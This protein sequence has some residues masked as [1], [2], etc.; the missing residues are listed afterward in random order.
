MF[1]PIGNPLRSRKFAPVVVALRRRPPQREPLPACLRD[2]DKHAMDFIIERRRT[3]YA[4]T[5]KI[6]SGR[7]KCI[8][9][10]HWLAWRWRTKE[11]PLLS[12]CGTS[13]PR[14]GQQ[15]R[16]M[17][18]QQR[19][20][21]LSADASYSRDLFYCKIYQNYTSRYVSLFGGE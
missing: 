3:A 8:K 5:E 20:C 16:A 2:S 13:S 12:D 14:P 10:L 11:G 7:I 15:Q 6:E 18:A 9:M 1:L 21:A 4:A 17:R 19:C